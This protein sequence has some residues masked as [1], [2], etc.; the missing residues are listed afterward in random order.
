MKSFLFRRI[1]FVFLVILIIALVFIALKEEKKDVFAQVW[2]CDINTVPFQWGTFS[3]TLGGNIVN[4]N[5]NLPYG[6]LVQRTISG[7][8]EPLIGES[9]DHKTDTITDVDYQVRKLGTGEVVVDWTPVFS[10]DWPVG[11]PI[12]SPDHEVCGLWCCQNGHD[13]GFNIDV[14][15]T[16]AGLSYGDY[17]VRIRARTDSD[18]VYHYYGGSGTGF[19]IPDITDPT[20]DIAY[21]DGW[22]KIVLNYIA[23]TEDDAESGI[24]SGNVDVRSR[25]H[26]GTYVD[27]GNTGLLDGGST[28]NGFNFTG[29]DC[30]DYQFRYKVTDN[31]GN[32]SN[33]CDDNGS[34][35]Q[36]CNPGW[37]TKVDITDPTANISFSV[38]P[39]TTICQSTFDV[40][41]S[42]GDTCSDVASGIVQK[43]QRTLSGAYG[44]WSLHSN[45]RS[46]F[47]FTGSNGYCY[48]F[49]YMSFDN[50]GN[51][52]TWATSGEVCIDTSIS[53]YVP[54]LT[55]PPSAWLNYNPIFRADVS[56]PTNQNVRAHFNITRVSK[57]SRNVGFFWKFKLLSF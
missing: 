11:S 1:A 2:D 18:G 37:T 38:A 9:H 46:S 48:E 14:G 3:T 54:T 56:D 28:I 55:D 32:I 30:T 15:P 8:D 47:S 51:N 24:S 5:S 36:F 27:W 35:N 57:W 42:D 40:N 29:A 12:C 44:N 53:P 16:G 21:N 20:C 43:R 39:D 23:L 34:A 31:A 26:G 10:M 22:E 52:S 45:T 19:S 50:A 13:L 49:R 41:L 7:C 4:I 6:F 25:P 33:G 17:W